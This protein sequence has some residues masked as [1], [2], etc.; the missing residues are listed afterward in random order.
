MENNELHQLHLTELD[1]R[2]RLGAITEHLDLCAYYLNMIGKREAFNDELNLITS[3]MSSLHNHTDEFASV[4]ISAFED[5]IRE[6]AEEKFGGSKRRNKTPIT[7]SMITKIAWD[8]WEDIVCDNDRLALNNIAR[9]V[10]VIYSLEK[11]MFTELYNRWL[12]DGKQKVLDHYR[13]WNFKTKQ[14]NI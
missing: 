8:V 14:I 10:D 12:P 4:P 1:L 2:L 3:N 6:A 13:G 5:M 11:T 9:S 7:R